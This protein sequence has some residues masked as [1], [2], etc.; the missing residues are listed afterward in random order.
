MKPPLADHQ[1]HAID[2]IHKYKRGLLADPPGLGKTR[3][4][5]EAFDGAKVLVVA[6]SLII[7]GGTWEDELNRWSN[8]STKY[9]IAP[10]SQLNQ[11]AK[12]GRGSGTTP[13]NALREEY[14]GH[15]DAV[16]V[17]EAHY[18][19]GRKTSWTWAV[20]Q[21]ARNTD[22]LLEMTGTP[23]A[24]WAPDLFPILQAIFPDKARPG[25]EYGSYWRWV[26]QWFEILPN[27]Q[28]RSEFAKT[29]G[30]LLACTPG[31][32]NLPNTQP[33]EHYAD[34]MVA[35]LGGHILR[36]RREDCLDLPPVTTQIVNTPMSA[37]GKRAY[38][39]MKKDYMATLGDGSEVVSWTTGSRQ[40]MLDRLTTSPWL[41]EDPATRGDP[42]GGKLDQLAFDLANR[43]DPTVVFAHYRDT[44]EACARVAVNIGA[45]ADYVHGGM[46]RRQAGQVVQ[47][48]KNGKLDVLVGSLD[49]MAEGLQL[50]RADQLIMVESSYKP[51]RNEQ[52]RMR[53][54]R[55]GQTRPVTIR[56][57]V[58]PG[59]VDTR[60]RQLVATKSDHQ[61][62][63]LSARDFAEIL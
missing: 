39:Q 33:C 35:N 16:I 22:H 29:I 10:Y 45:R 62:R 2:W 63:M 41:L 37:A 7:T 34:F 1:Q 4:A 11:R 19:K 26:Q 55:M 25:R 44:V 31:C 13:I 49:T 56:E 50:T 30:G 6:P 18:T 58:T 15:W 38:N 48:F 24:G 53:V 54:D 8:D 20:Q 57:Y 17:D 43:S 27:Y 60:K 47:D 23:I 51:Y 36:R 14:T 32:T 21:L 28:A 12:T 59:S 52:A 3:V 40:V 9:T 46:D 61:M 42:R 5:I